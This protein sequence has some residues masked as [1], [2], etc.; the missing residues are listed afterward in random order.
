VPRIWEYL[1]EKMPH[2]PYKKADDVFYSYWGGFGD[3][4]DAEVKKIQKE[5][6]GRRVTRAHAG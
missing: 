5:V 4:I 2:F 3:G 6:E 1:A